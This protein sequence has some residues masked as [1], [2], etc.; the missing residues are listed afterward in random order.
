MRKHLF[1]LACAA[2]LLATPAGALPTMADG[3]VHTARIEYEPGTLSVF[4]DDLINPAVTASVHSGTAAA[5]NAGA[6]WIGFTSGLGTGESDVDILNWS[7]TNGSSF[8]YSD[9]G[10]VADINLVG[11]AIQSVDRLRLV[12]QGRPAAQYFTG[13]AW[14]NTQVFV[15]DGFSTTFDFQITTA[16]FVDGFAF[17]IQNV[18]GFALG[19]CGFGIGY[20]NGDNAGGRCDL[21]GDPDTIPGALAV[22]FDTFE[23]GA[24]F[25]NPGWPPEY[26]AGETLL[27]GTG[28]GGNH[29]AIVST[30]PEPTTVLLLACGLVGLVWR[31]VIARLA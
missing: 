16:N 11:S 1:T 14:F 12:N 8:S 21:Y 5:L 9:F 25:G 29:V 19:G 10:S 3:S 18:S 4:V 27:G 17:V 6:A 22:E 23:N 28:T 13:A 24:S 15:D 31:G 20:L 30:I 2:P 26:L 7:F